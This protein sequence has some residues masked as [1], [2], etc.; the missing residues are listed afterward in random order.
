MLYNMT[1][2]QVNTKKLCAFVSLW[3]IQTTA[4]VIVKKTSI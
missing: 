2:A 4:N 1:K 3:Q